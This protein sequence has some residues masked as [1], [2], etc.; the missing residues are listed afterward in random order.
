[1]EEIVEDTSHVAW[2]VDEVDIAAVAA[3]VEKVRT[4]VLVPTVEVLGVVAVEAMVAQEVMAV[5]QATTV[6]T[7]TD[8]LRRITR[9]AATKVAV[10]T[11]K[12][13]PL[14][15]SSTHGSRPTRQR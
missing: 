8:R 1:M 4:M 15:S 7:T 9:W 2:D 3:I 6:D 5:D 12:D 10:D 14:G 13:L 11:A